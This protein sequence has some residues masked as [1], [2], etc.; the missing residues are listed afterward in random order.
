MNFDSLKKQIKTVTKAAF[1][2]NVSNYGKDICA[3]ALVSDDGAMTVVPFTN[4][5]THLQKT[6][7]EDPVY[8]EVYEFEPAEWY[9]SDGANEEINAICK[10]L[11][12]EVL[13]DNIDFESF[14]NQLFETCV[15]VLE[16]LQQDNFFKDSLQKDILVL[17][18]ISDT[19]EPEEKLTKWAKRTNTKTRGE[20]Y[21]AYQNKVW[22]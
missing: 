16:E 17:F 11:N 22:E 6:Q 13:S 20:A 1:L 7:K 4:T 3:F 12:Q 5:A 18:S 19:D 9:T 15:E 8:K 2:E 21:E 14:K 10:I